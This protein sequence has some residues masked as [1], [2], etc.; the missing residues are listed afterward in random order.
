MARQ[1]QPCKQAAG[2]ENPGRGNY[3]AVYCTTAHCME[4]PVHLG[5]GNISAEQNEQS[6]ECQ[7]V[8]GLYLSIIHGKEFTVHS[9]YDQKP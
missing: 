3:S 4:M 5:H 6:S 2:E 8:A 9:M 1:S 7:T